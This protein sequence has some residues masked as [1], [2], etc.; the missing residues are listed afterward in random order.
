[1]ATW[2]RR[3]FANNKPTFPVEREVRTTIKIATNRAANVAT[4]NVTIFF[5]NT[6]NLV[7]GMFVSG[8]NVP[9]TANAGF[10][11]SNVSIVTVNL[12]NVVIS[13][14]LTANTSVG[15]VFTFDTL[16]PYKANTVATSYNANTYLVTKTRIANTQ[17]IGNKVATD[18]WVHV[19]QGKG[20]IANL[21]VSNV[22]STLTYSNAYLAFS[23][24]GEV[25][26]N[27]QIRVSG[28]SNV[29]IQINYQGRGYVN[30]PTVSATGANN[31][32]LIFTVTPG[33]RLGRTQ[34]ETLVALSNAVALSATSGGP[35]FPG[36]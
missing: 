19:E 16:I 21:S 22:V 29:S 3:D 1:M 23:T 25:A 6:A 7:A 11:K 36:L 5:A 2:G 34:C 26:A 9:T 12:S 32:N 4:S 8:N 15:D 24:T 28:T 17:G 10:F 27:A 18:G 20:H 35:Y 31:G 13:R 30:I 33:G 14:A